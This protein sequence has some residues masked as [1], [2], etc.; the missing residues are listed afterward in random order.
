MYYKKQ[1]LLRYS[2]FCILSEAKEMHPQALIS[3]KFFSLV[4]GVEN[5]II[6]QTNFK[7]EKAECIM[8]IVLGWV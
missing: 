4:S 8:H 5:F 6:L 2:Y 3:S 1:K 7:C